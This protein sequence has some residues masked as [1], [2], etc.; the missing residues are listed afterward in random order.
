MR[1]G[2]AGRHG[3]K[4]LTTEMLV[5]WNRFK[6]T[7]LASSANSPKAVRWRG[8]FLVRQIS[9]KLLI[10]DI[11]AR[12]H[13]FKQNSSSPSGERPEGRSLEG[14]FFL[15][16]RIPEK[17]LMT[18]MVASCHSLKITCLAP[19]GCSLEGLLF[20]SDKFPKSF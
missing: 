14:L 20:W 11:V 2:F 1:T 16:R 19:P 9:E 5:R 17:V 12:W 4:S 10:P 8:F 6:R 3:R 15:V 7:L 18:E 13:S